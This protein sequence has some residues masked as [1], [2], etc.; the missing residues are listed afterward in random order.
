MCWTLLESGGK[1]KIVTPKGEFRDLIKKEN[2][3]KPSPSWRCLEARMAVCLEEVAEQHTENPEGSTGR[4]S[5]RVT[6]ED[7]GHPWE[8]LTRAGRRAGWRR[9][10]RAEPEG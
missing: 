7:T 6:W 4:D 8:G 1:G 2:C 10:G 9:L 3:I 5:L